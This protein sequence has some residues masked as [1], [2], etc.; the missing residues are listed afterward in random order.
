MSI[1]PVTYSNTASHARIGQVSKRGLVVLQVEGWDENQMAI[2]RERSH[3][4]RD[5]EK[6]KKEQYL[7]K[8]KL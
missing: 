1:Q 6:K 5:G 3:M 2:K 7:T 8:H 4:S